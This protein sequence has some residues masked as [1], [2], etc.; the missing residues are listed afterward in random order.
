MLKFDTEWNMME[1][2]HLWICAR[3]C[4]E[5]QLQEIMDHAY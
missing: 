2:Y 3:F 1:L 5:N 4:Y